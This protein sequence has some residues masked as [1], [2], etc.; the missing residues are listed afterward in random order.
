MGKNFAIYAP[1]KGLIS[2]VDKKLKRMYE[3]KEQPHQKVSKDMNRHFSKEDMHEVN[4]HMK[5]KLNIRL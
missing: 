2:R 1:D 5:K 4:K 3:K